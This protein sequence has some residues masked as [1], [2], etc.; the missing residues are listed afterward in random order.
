MHAWDWDQV[1]RDDSL[2]RGTLPLAPLARALS[3][4]ERLDC[5]VSL[6]DR[7]AVPGVVQL[8]LWW[9]P[10]RPAQLFLTLGWEYD[11][12]PKP[13]V[14]PAWEPPDVPPKPWLMI[15]I[16][17]IV[18]C[19][20]AW[21]CYKAEHNWIGIVTAFVMPFIGIY[22]FLLTPMTPPEDP[23]EPKPFDLGEFLETNGKRYVPTLYAMASG[24]VTGVTEF[25]DGIK[26]GLFNFFGS[27][28][29]TLLAPFA[30][31]IAKGIQLG[32]G[33]SAVFEVFAAFQD[34]P[35]A[36]T[37]VIIS[38]TTAVQLPDSFGFVIADNKYWHM[39]QAAF[40]ERKGETEESVVKGASVV[41]KRIEQQL[42]QIKEEFDILDDL[43]LI[44]I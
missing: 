16:A 38:S 13:Y 3:F 28:I 7:Q 5:A 1:G 23:D 10:D 24:V 42:D 31:Q 44:H 43:S 6:D 39:A 12:P 40:D 21:L 18:P 29:G 17:V 35:N 11:V 19:L 32:M 37:G 30:A 34:I 25:V 8:V 14:P 2:G 33:F 15:A 36:A 41:L 22:A 27:I 9:R 4:G 20:T 26:S